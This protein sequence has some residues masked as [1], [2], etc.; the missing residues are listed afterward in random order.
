MQIV[1]LLFFSF[2]YVN[3]QAHL[4]IM[5]YE[6]GNFSCDVNLLPN[7][8]QSQFICFTDK[9]FKVLATKHNVLLRTLYEMCMYFIGGLFG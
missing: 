7:L 2:N 5:R 4:L 3:N 8:Q 6:V 1:Y 9:F